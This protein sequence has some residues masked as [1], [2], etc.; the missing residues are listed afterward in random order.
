[1]TKVAFVFEIA[2]VC[3]QDELYKLKLEAVE[4]VGSAI[5]YN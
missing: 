5:F 3:R 2:G 4:D 1:M